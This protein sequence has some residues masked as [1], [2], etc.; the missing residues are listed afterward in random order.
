MILL[1]FDI[2]L[3]FWLE[4]ADD[5]VVNIEELEEF[6]IIVVDDASAKWRIPDSPE[7]EA[8]TAL[9]DA[10]W[11]WYECEEMGELEAAG[12]PPPPP[13]PPW[14]G[15]KDDFS[16]VW[17]LHGRG[18]EPPDNQIYKSHILRW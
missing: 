15:C 17:S 9:G 12:P 11:C 3:L 14:L 7:E 18:E 1:L 16:G 8:L 6:A 5:D 13:P 10:C 2:E 4:D